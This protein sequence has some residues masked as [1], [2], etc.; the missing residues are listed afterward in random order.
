MTVPLIQAMHLTLAGGVPGM[1][2][3]GDNSELLYMLASPQPCHSKA[4]QKLYEGT[5]QAKEAAQ[6]KVVNSVPRVLTVYIDQGT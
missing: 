6:K 3:E 4:T 2:L 5:H 1:L